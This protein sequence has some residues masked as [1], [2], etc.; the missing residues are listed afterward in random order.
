MTVC[1]KLFVNG[2]WKLKYQVDTWSKGIIYTATHKCSRRPFIV[3]F[4]RI[5]PENT[6]LRH[7]YDSYMHI[8]AVCNK[9]RGFPTVHFYGEHG[10]YNALVLDYV[11]SSL[12]SIMDIYPCISHEMTMSIGIQALNTLEFLHA[13]G[14]IHGN[15]NP[16]NVRFMDS[17]LYLI[18]LDHSKQFCNGGKSKHICFRTGN[19]KHGDVVFASRNS[20]AGFSLSRRDDLE[21]LGYVLVYIYTGSLPWSQFGVSEKSKIH[22]L[23]HCIESSKLC[24]EMTEDMSSYFRVVRSLEYPEKPNYHM[25]QGLL[26]KALERRDEAEVYSFSTGGLPLNQ[27]TNPCEIEGGYSDAREKHARNEKEDKHDGETPPGKS[28]GDQEV[29]EGLVLEPRKNLFANWTTLSSLSQDADCNSSQG[30]SV[31]RFDES[32]RDQSTVQ[33]LE[34]APGTKRPSTAVSRQNNGLSLHTTTVPPVD[35]VTDR[36]PAEG[37]VRDHFTASPGGIAVQHSRPTEPALPVEP[38]HNQAS[39]HSAAFVGQHLPRKNFYENERAALVH[40][41]GFDKGPYQG[42]TAGVKALPWES[43]TDIQREA[44]ARRQAA[45]SGFPQRISKKGQEDVFRGRIL[46]PYNEAT[47][48]WAEHAYDELAAPYQAHFLKNQS[49][50]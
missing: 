10:R 31:V 13:K 33:A 43:L 17:S 37:P 41:Q 50:Q 12:V 1:R 36:R 46:T 22:E 7:E 47:V 29:N 15:L 28:G 14:F 16:N 45:G 27:S 18:N 35:V 19:R 40:G 26:R 38:G 9:V 23:K 20:H 11:I 8:G 44:L 3:K 2:I 49:L 34:L 21:S 48:R 25:L 4:E 5:S 6:T 30:S 32:K 39:V 42:P 24:E